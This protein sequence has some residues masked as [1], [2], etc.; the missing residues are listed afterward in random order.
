[1]TA[2]VRRVMGSSATRERKDQSRS[3]ARSP[4]KESSDLEM[5][6]V[7]ESKVGRDLRRGNR[8]ERA[9]VNTEEAL[10]RVTEQE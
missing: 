6:R 4:R 2:T 7:W 3:A 5:A 10:L 9:G 8:G 1:M